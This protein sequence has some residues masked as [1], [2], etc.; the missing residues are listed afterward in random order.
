MIMIKQKRE[1]EWNKQISQAQARLCTFLFSANSS[2]LVCIRSFLHSFVRRGQSFWIFISLRANGKSNLGR[3]SFY[4]HFGKSGKGS[5]E[6]CNS[7]VGACCER[8]RWMW[9][10]LCSRS[11]LEGKS[12]DTPVTPDFTHRLSVKERYSAPRSP[13]PR[14]FSYPL[15]SMLN[16]DVLRQ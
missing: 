4:F 12:F 9:F 15:F 6:K 16:A 8:A 5:G 7:A 10:C 2:P 14:P 3:C 1:T 11:S 13:P